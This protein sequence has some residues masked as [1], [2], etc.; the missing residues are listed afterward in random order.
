MAASVRVRTCSA[1]LHG[2]V[3]LR[4]FDGNFQSLFLRQLAKAGQVLGISNKAEDMPLLAR[5]SVE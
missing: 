1:S 3:I 2:A 4:D 5:R